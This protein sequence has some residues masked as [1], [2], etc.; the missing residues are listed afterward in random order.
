MDVK[1]QVNVYYFLVGQPF[2]KGT[3]LTF[4][5]INRDVLDHDRES[6]LREETFLVFLYAVIN[7][8]FHEKQESYHQ[9]G[10][11]YIRELRRIHILVQII[12]V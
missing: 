9:Y 7:L 8:G 12:K 1:T 5:E 11:R 10:D 3:D 4:S 6:A 2:E